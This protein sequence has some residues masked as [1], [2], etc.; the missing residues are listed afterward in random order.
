ML[1]LISL[2]I[3]SASGKLRLVLCLC[4]LLC[5]MC[6]GFGTK[7]SGTDGY[8]TRTR[9][10]SNSASD[11][12][13]R[14]A[15]FSSGSLARTSRAD[16]T[17]PHMRLWLKKSAARPAGTRFARRLDPTRRRA[18]PLCRRALSPPPSDLAATTLRELLL[19]LL[20]VG[21]LQRARFRRLRTPTLGPL[22]RIYNYYDN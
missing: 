6:F 14:A 22:P 10:F 8:L 3:A 15:S 1:F 2:D 21:R 7:F 4:V 19:E 16:G 11:S 18:L 13:R 20:A 5:F 12:R 17:R 9:A